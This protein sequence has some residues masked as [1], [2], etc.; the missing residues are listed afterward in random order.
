MLI[1]WNIKCDIYASLCVVKHCAFAVKMG[2]S[3]TVCIV[4]DCITVLMFVKLL[5]APPTISG[6]L[7]CQHTLAGGWW[8][9]VTAYWA[10]LELHKMP[11]L[12]FSPVFEW[13]C[14]LLC[15]GGFVDSITRAVSL[16]RS[17]GSHHWGESSLS[18]IST[19]DNQTIPAWYVNN[20]PRELMPSN[21]QNVRIWGHTPKPRQEGCNVSPQLIL[22]HWRHT[23][24]FPGELKETNNCCLSDRN[25]CI[26]TLMS[27]TECEWNRGVLCLSDVLLS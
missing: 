10:H 22:V 23:I 12:H 9:R 16:T 8:G 15:L 14:T 3:I 26:C 20:W 25:C 6:G 1:D 27:S 11:H 13:A 24:K 5:E 21:Q 17:D 19:R 4:L 18:Q 2:E 7:F